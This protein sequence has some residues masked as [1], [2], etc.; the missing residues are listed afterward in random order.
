MPAEIRPASAQDVPLILGFIRELAEFEK[1]SNQV[2]ATEEALRASL[3]PA[4]CRPAAECVLAFEKGTPAGYALFF[5]TFSTFLAK[6]GLWLEDLYVKPPLRHR[7]IGKTLIL[8]VAKLANDRGCGRME[9]SVLDWNAP[10]IKFYDSLGAKSLP[11]WR[12]C[13]LTGE[14]LARYS[15]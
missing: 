10:A 3:F 11:D 14:D 15:R 1:L 12:I 13:R 9:W 6:P 5:T 4:N 8:H 7:G 2:V